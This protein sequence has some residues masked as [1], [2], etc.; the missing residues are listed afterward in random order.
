MTAVFKLCVTPTANVCVPLPAARLAVA[1]DIDT[2]TGDGTAI[3]D[4]QAL[5]PAV[6]GA[7]ELGVV[8]FT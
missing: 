6:V 3:A 8:E 2:M 4:R 7:G 1:G 5:E